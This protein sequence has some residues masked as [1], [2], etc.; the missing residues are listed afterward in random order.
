MYGLLD[1][2]EGFYAA[3]TKDMI[4]RGDWITPTL[5][6]T[7]WFEKPILAYWLAI[8]SVRIFGPDFGPRLPSVLCTL[9]T[10][11]LVYWFTKRH[12]SPQAARLASLIYATNLLVVGIGRM[13]MTDAV[14][15]LVLSLALMLLYESSTQKRPFSV[16]CWFGIGALV[17][18]AVLAK[19]PVALILFGGVFFWSKFK[20]ESFKNLLRSPWILGFLMAILVTSTW[21]IPCY[22][23]NGSTF[24]D[25]FLINQN[26]GRFTGGDLAHKVPA[27]TIPIY[28][29]ILLLVSF[30][31]VSFWIRRFWKFVLAEFRKKDAETKRTSISYLV[32][33]ALVPLIFFSLSGTKLPHYIL[34]AVAPIAILFAT[35]LQEIQTQVKIEKL[36][37]GWSGLLLVLAQFIFATDYN[38]R[39]KEVRIAAE[40]LNY[41]L[42]P[43]Y[44][45]R[46][47]GSGD[48]S[49]SLTLRDT[50]H[51]SFFFYFDGL[52]REANSSKDWLNVGQSYA[53]WCPKELLQSD[54]SLKPYSREETDA[55]GRLYQ[56]DQTIEQVSGL[57]KY[58]I[59][60]CLSRQI[61][62]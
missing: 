13:M 16:K 2:D 11:F 27:W 38:N 42:L 23:K 55:K 49:I 57:Q 31:P 51:P 15:V 53:I 14:L 26:I 7:P 18:L 59:V 61:G 21:Y 45:Y 33:W 3:V 40:H 1:L 58:A 41:Q 37:L 46:I 43:V 34:P 29:P 4:H 9:A 44:I 28:F 6:G 22:L 10:I 8:P 24:V 20:L 25:E 56:V 62:G 12:V 19:G 36:L 60:K 30:I 5:N 47:G 52:V 35:T 17:G 32:I 50:S 48:T 39:M 54:P